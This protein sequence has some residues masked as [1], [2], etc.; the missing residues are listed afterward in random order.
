[1]T[2]FRV[3]SFARSA[4]AGPSGVSYRDDLRVQHAVRM[5]SVTRESLLFSQLTEAQ[6]FLPAAALPGWPP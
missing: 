3:W 4:G 2:T 1:M 5:S 6:F